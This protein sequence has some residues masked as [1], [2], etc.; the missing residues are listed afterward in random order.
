MT[1]SSP[2]EGVKVGAMEGRYSRNPWS[3][4]DFSFRVK[5]EAS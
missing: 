5:A 1:L 2:D 3:G 4:S